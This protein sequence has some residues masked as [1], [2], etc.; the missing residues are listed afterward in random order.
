M[1]LA[2]A[3]PPAKPFFELCPYIPTTDWMKPQMSMVPEAL[4]HVL[5]L[6][7]ASFRLTLVAPS[8]TLTDTQPLHL[9]DASESVPAWSLK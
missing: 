7:I 3:R 8:T 1:N 6:L 9:H 4:N 2:S 5:L